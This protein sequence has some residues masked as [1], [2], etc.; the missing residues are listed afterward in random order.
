MISLRRF[1]LP[2]FF[3]H[4]I[5]AT[6]APLIPTQRRGLAAHTVLFGVGQVAA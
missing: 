3:F 5:P 4:P 6:T 2:H 1:S